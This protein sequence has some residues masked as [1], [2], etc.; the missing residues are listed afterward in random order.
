MEEWKPQEMPGHMPKRLDA[1]KP[2]FVKLDKFEAARESLDIIKE[3]LNSIDQLLRT[4]RD[5]KMKEDEE[6]STWE[7]EIESI[8]AR[9]NSVS[10]EIFEGNHG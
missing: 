6:L 2:I 9:I 3:K 7:K 8:K 4:T 5:A 10:S 1:N